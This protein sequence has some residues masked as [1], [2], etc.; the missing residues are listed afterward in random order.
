MNC[1]TIEAIALSL[2]SAKL[3]F[4]SVSREMHL[5]DH[6]IARRAR[7]QKHHAIIPFLC[8]GYGEPFYS[9]SFD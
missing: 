8:R 2:Q 6:A 3:S 9:C 5:T 4:G 7:A 1:I